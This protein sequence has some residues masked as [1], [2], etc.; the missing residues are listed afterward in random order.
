MQ[1]YAK[2]E[3][4]GWLSRQEGN[5]DRQKVDSGKKSAGGRQ[6]IK[7]AGYFHIV[8]GNVVLFLPFYTID[9]KKH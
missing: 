3:E 7:L 5:L 1:P 2:T 6:N 8:F 4:G 9:T